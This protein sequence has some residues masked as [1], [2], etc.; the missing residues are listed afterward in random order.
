MYKLDLNVTITTT[1]T[2]LVSQI[3]QRNRCKRTHYCFSGF[4]DSAS[5]SQMR[6]YVNLLI[7]DHWNRADMNNMMMEFLQ[8]KIK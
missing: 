7:A 2:T 6:V 4:H 3:L 8:I 1:G 5:I